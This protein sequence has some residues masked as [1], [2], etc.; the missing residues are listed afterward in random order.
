[1]TLAEFARCS[2][3]AAA[4]LQAQ[5][6]QQAIIA[7]AARVDDAGWKAFIKGLE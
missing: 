7:R 1:M 3:A 4:R 2:R 5:A 6:R